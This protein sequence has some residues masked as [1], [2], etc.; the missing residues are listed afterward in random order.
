MT[1]KKRSKNVPI[2]QIPAYQMSFISE[3]TGTFL[4]NLF[5][6][7]IHRNTTLTTKCFFKFS[8]EIDAKINY[9]IVLGFHELF[10]HFQFGF[11]QKVTLTI[12]Q[13]VVQKADFVFLRTIVLTDLI[14]SRTRF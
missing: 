4:L 3:T 2:A 6:S 9:F 10:A 13:H 12:D 5:R 7:N 1:F 8:K 11:D 14:F